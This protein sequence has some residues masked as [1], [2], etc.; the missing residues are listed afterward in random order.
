MWLWIGVDGC[1]LLSYVDRCGSWW[2]GVEDCGGGMVG[3]GL[4]FGGGS[5]GSW[6]V[7]VGLGLR[8]VVVSEVG[9]G[10]WWHGGSSAEFQWW[11]WCSGALLGG[12]TWRF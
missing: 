12:F 8:I 9:R 3:L 11:L 7:V 2:F 6:W 10:S 4:S 1:D 5:G